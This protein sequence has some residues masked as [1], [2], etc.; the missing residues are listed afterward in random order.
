[1]N[2]LWLALGLLIGGLTVARWQRRRRGAQNR[3]QLEDALKHLFEQEYRIRRGSLASL[4]GALRMPE[5]SVVALVGRMS[6]QGLV[7]ARGQE[8]DLTPE[9]ERL[10]LQIV[11]AHRLLERWTAPLQGGAKPPPPRR[12]PPPQTTPPP[13][14]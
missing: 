8:F 13:T 1:M 6:A 14:I 10:A 9:G 2:W 3:Q 7:Q 4:A 11:R 5:D 12:P